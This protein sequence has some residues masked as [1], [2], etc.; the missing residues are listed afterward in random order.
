MSLFFKNNVLIVVFFLGFFG[1]SQNKKQ[2]SDTL[3]T[4]K[5]VIVK[6]FNPTINDAFKIHPEPNFNEGEKAPKDPLSFNINSVPVAS[7]F[8]PEKTKSIAVKKENPEA[9]F[10]NYALLGVGNFGNVLAEA[11]SSIDIN[12]ESQFTALLEHQSSQGGIKEVRLDDFY[13]DTG[14]QLSFGKQQK[15]NQWLIDLE[16]QHQLYNWYGL[17]DNLEITEEQ[18]N[19]IDPSHSFVDVNLGG[20]LELDNEIF[21]TANIRFRHFRDDYESTENNLK[22]NSKFTIPLNDNPILLPVE[23]DYLSGEFA[24]NNVFEGSEYSFLI[25]GIKPSVAIKFRGVDVKI[26]VSGFLNND[27]ENSDLT[28]SI[29]P[30]LTANYNFQAYNLSIFGGATGG[31]KQNTYHKAAEKNPFIAPGIGVRPTNQMF[32]LFGGVQ[33]QWQENFTYM[34]K[35]EAEFVKDYAAFIKNPVLNS[36]TGNLNYGFNNSFGYFYQDYKAAK[37]T[38]EFGYEEEG[39]FNVLLRTTY[40]KFNQTPR[41]PLN[42]PSFTSTI[43]GDYIVNSTWRLGASLFYVGPRNSSNQFNDDFFESFMELDGYVDFNLR[44]DYKITDQWSAFALGNNLTGQNY[45]R[46]LDYPVQGIQL[47]VGAKYQF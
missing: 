32:N 23:V 19:A 16:L 28:L 44:A 38:G 36:A 24:D 27:F 25:V 26:G 37:I 13:Y 9:S 20:N 14:L 35:G 22:L 15:R 46:W 8:V 6:T 17:S 33:G 2:E 47:L 34:L 11:F 30:N 40:A 18:F 43:K 10:K 42:V 3:S 4:E 31:V 5:V 1:F 12:R 21:N 39:L 29:H 41:Q 7:T 45:E